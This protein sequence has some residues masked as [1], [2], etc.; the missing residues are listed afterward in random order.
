MKTTGR[1]TT[2]EVYARSADFSRKIASCGAQA[3]VDALERADLSPERE[4]LRR[5]ASRLADLTRRALAE[6]R[7][8]RGDGRSVGR[9]DD[10]AVEAVGDHLRSPGPGA[11]NHGETRRERFEVHVAERLVAAPPHDP[12]GRRGPALRVGP[13]APP[14]RTAGRAPAG[15]PSP[16]RAG[17]APAA[18]P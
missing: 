5:P 9:I 11:G 16:R 14:R 10:R 18:R 2:S 15:P 6:A 13:G 17:L 4:G 8:P 3:L 1:R 7:E 12:V